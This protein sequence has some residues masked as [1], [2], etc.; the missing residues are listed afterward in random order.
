M[1]KAV[2]KWLWGKPILL[3]TVLLIIPNL[4][5]QKFA[6]GIYFHR[7]FKPISYGIRSLTGL[8]AWPIGQIIFYLGILALTIG[9]ALAIRKAVKGKSVKVLRKPALKGLMI[10]SVVYF[11][12][13]FSWGVNYKRTSLAEHLD[14]D[15]AQITQGEILKLGEWLVEKT[16]DAAIGAENKPALDFQEMCFEAELSYQKLGSYNPQFA[17]EN[18]VVKE[19]FVPQTMSYAGI[20]G[21][22]FP[23]TAEA[24]VNTH[25][26]K[27]RW[28]SVITHE[29]AHQTGIGSE[30]EANFVAFLA[31]EMNENP[32][33]QFAAYYSALRTTLWHVE[34]TLVQQ[35]LIERLNP[36]TKAISELNRTYW[37]EHQSV[38]HDIGDWV[39]DKFLK[40][41]GQEQGIRS[42]RLYAKL[43]V[44]WERK[45]GVLKQKSS[46]E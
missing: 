43:L 33:F 40:A 45:Y 11:L 7:I 15:T 17:I 31:C 42:Y 30:D 22:Y 9:L 29:M 21:I 4:L 28:P 14:L 12:F 3:S 10:F 1:I 2:L 5:S 37:E 16:N 46:I 23:F 26:P 19:V 36:Q 8:S 44:G 6:D 35:A 25:I 13:Q 39:N 27:N 34:D 18:P 24:N 41:N 20:S 32:H 38:F